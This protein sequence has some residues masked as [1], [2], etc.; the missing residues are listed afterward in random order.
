MP[1]CSLVLGSA[2]AAQIEEAEGG[3]AQHLIGVTCLAVELGGLDR[4]RGNSDASLVEQAEVRA[5]A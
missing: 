5:A 1:G 3:A 4:V 2:K